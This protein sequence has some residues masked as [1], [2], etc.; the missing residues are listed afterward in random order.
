[1]PSAS[2]QIFIT[3]LKQAHQSVTLARLSVFKA[4]LSNKL[5]SMKELIKLLAPNIDRASVYRNVELLVSLGIV[6]RVYI[7]WK[8]KL[9]LTE[10][11]SG[12]HHHLICTKCGAIS[13]IH[14][15]VGLEQ[16]IYDITKL[17]GYI[18]QAHQL[19][20]QGLCGNCAST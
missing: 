7:G 12:H 9:E 19:E 11:Y 20:I 15:E 5:L 10:A 3:T 18:L 4:L 1:M 6:E 8:Y 14:G 16:Q 2:E 17:H 13:N